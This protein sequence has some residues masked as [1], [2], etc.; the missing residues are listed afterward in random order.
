MTDP[1]VLSPTVQVFGGRR[2]YLSGAYFGRDGHRLHRVVYAA[3]HGPIPA[4]QHVHHVN[5]DRHDNRLANLK[6]LDP[7]EHSAHHGATTTP[8]QREARRRNVLAAAAGNA[9]ISTE[10]RAAASARGWE[11]IV[12]AVIACEVCGVPVETP[13]PGRARY[14][15][16]TCRQRARRARRR[17]P[18]AQGLRP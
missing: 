15:G 5:G 10:D 6:L 8:A 9:L 1:L 17:T 7:G 16:G 11:S 2:Y 4:G 12:R 13:F 18:S 3:A 14:C